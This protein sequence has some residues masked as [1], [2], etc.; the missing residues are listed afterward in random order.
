MH[1]VDGKFADHVTLF[2]SNMR[3][4]KCYCDLYKLITAKTV[5]RHFPKT[6]LHFYQIYLKKQVKFPLKFQEPQIST[7]FLL[8]LYL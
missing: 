3:I 7:I 5:H 1:I 8:Y 6:C 2:H 4:S